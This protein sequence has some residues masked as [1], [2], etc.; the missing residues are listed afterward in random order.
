MGDEVSK[1]WGEKYTRK[2]QCRNAFIAPVA[3]I[4]AAASSPKTRVACPFS[5]SSS[6]RS[7][8]G[9]TK[10][11]RLARNPRFYSRVN[12]AGCGKDKYKVLKGQFR[13]V[14]D[15]LLYGFSIIVRLS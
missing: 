13:G 7:A 3:T 5:T 2:G 8:A 14:K 11:A 1:A 12:E 15:T 6:V 10:N 4:R 9:S